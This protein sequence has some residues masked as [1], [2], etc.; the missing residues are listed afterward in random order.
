MTRILLTL[1]VLVCLLSNAFTQNVFNVNDPIIRYDKNQSLGSPLNP[2]PNK[3]GLQKWVSTPTNGVSV[4]TGQFDVSSFKQYYINAAGG[5][6]AFRIKFPKSYTNPD[7]INKKYPMMLFLHGAGEVGCPSNGGIYN[8]EKQIWLGGS[9]FR[10]RVNNNQFDGF[11]L[12]PQLVNADGC[13]GAWGSAPIAN[14]KAII[15]MVDSL[16]KYARADIDRMMVNGLSGGGYGAWRMAAD[17]PTRV[18]KIMPSAA[19]G[20]TANRALF[21]HIPI[22]FATGGKDPDPSPAQADY[23]LTRMKEIGAD[24]RYTQFLR[25]WSLSMVPTLARTRLC[26]RYE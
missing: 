11:L 21:V 2:D 19:A 10:D 13:W 24:I 4:G 14:F 6:M 22:W 18:A 7:S 1:T 15:A 12:Y 16:A 8:N 5:K 3:L 26:T 23:A 9:L 17:W 25:S 20:S